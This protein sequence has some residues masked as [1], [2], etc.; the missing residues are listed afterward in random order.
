MGLSRR[1]SAHRR[2]PRYLA[3]SGLSVYPVDCAL[4]RVAYD[5]L[6][7]PFACQTLLDKRAG[8]GALLIMAHVTGPLA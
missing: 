4:D 7:A 3:S 6:A 2:D 1:A 5:H 8:G